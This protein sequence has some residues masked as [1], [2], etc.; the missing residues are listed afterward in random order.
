MWNDPIV[1]ELHR[2]RKE[3]AE[4]FGYDIRAIVEDLQKSQQQHAD[5]LVSY[6]PKPAPRRKTA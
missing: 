1:E 6:P 5:R 3:H 4:R 2:I